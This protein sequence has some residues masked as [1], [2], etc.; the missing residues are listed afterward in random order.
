MVS[1]AKATPTPP[2]PL[3]LTS[4]TTKSTTSCNCQQSSP[5]LCCFGGGV[6]GGTVCAAS[7]P[8]LTHTPPRPQ[9]C[10]SIFRPSPKHHQHQQ[11]YVA[12]TRQIPLKHT[13]IPTNDREGMWQFIFFPEKLHALPYD[14]NLLFCC[15]CVCFFFF[16]SFDHEGT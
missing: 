14:K 7:P 10:R 4:T 12:T 9:P 2:P 8:P 1:Q 16:S 3:P 15:V 6:S 13:L 5:R 11:Q